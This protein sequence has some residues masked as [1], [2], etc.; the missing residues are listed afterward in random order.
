MFNDNSANKIA[1]PIENNSDLFINTSL[2]QMSIRSCLISQPKIKLIS[3][4]EQLFNDTNLSPNIFSVILPPYL[5]G[6]NSTN[7]QINPEL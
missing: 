4:S 3:H 6:K 1:K 2:N 5:R 7:S